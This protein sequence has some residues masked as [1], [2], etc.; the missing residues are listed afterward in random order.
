L[1][2]ATKQSG[3]K[4]TSWSNTY[5]NDVVQDVVRVFHYTG[6]DLSRTIDA[7]KVL[8][9][10]NAYELC[11]TLPGLIE[12]D[13]NS[14][15]CNTDLTDAIHVISSQLGFK[16]TVQKTISN[17]GGNSFCKYQVVAGTE[18]VY[19]SKQF[20]TSFAKIG[21]CPNINVSPNSYRDFVLTTSRLL[22]LH[23]TFPTVDL[24]AYAAAVLSTFP[25]RF[26]KNVCFSTWKVLRARDYSQPLAEM[27]YE[28]R[29]DGSVA[30][31]RGNGFAPMDLAPNVRGAIEKELLKL[32]AEVTAKG[33]FLILEAG[34]YP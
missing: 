32:A 34:Q 28:V 23:A 29:E 4:S 26:L 11:S 6:E 27:N 12:G 33:R 7:L 16:V 3:E 10:E 24:S 25:T 2:G 13:D 20:H 5:L 15:P 21:W 17:E 8:H 30:L 22:A 14:L 18:G 31:A 1:A 19:A 9:T